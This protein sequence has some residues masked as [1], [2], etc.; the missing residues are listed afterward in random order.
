LAIVRLLAAQ[1]AGPIGTEQQRIIDEV[2]ELLER[3]KQRSVL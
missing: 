2:I 1:R 3:A